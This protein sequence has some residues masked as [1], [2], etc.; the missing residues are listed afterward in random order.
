M[1]TLRG[2]RRLAEGCFVLWLTLVAGSVAAQAAVEEQPIRE[3]GPNL[4]RAQEHFV[5]GMNFF[6]AHDYREALREFHVAATLAPNAD[7]WFNIGRSYEELGEY[8]QAA[9]AL[10]RY[11]RDRVDAKDA[12]RVRLHIAR[13]EELVRAQRERTQVAPQTGSLRIHRRER[14]SQSHVFVD[15]KLLAPDAIAAP[16]FLPSGRHRLDV[17][18]P[19]HV[20]LRAV[21]DIEPGILTAAYVDLAPLTH[22]ETRPASHALSYVLFG[23]AGAGALVSASFAGFSLSQQAR[24]AVA[25]SDA[26]AQRADVALAGTAVCA[27]VAAIAYYAAERGARTELSRKP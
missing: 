3:S 16:L 10:E 25:S 1:T 13:L 5:L 9:S 8:A 23:V 27:L 2:M 20:P 12:S 14:S 22:A 4:T 15:G 19:E 24:G 17:I 21:V 26:W 11:L 18:E 6:R 7:V